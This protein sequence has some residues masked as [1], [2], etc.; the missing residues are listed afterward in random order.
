V[1]KSRFAKNQLWMKTPERRVNGLLLLA[2]AAEAAA[3]AAEAAA[4]AA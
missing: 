3:A 4:A 2:A 1:I